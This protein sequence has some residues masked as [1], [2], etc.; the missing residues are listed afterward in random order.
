ARERIRGCYEAQIVSLS[1]VLRETRAEPS[2]ASARERLE[3][4]SRLVRSL[5]EYRDSTRAKLASPEV[6]LDVVSVWNATEPRLTG[7]V[8]TVGPG[9]SFP[10]LR[11]AIDASRPG[12]LLKLGEEKHTWVPGPRDVLALTDVAIVGR[13]AG[14]TR[15][16]VR[17]DARFGRVRLEG[18]TLEGG[19]GDA[20]LTLEEGDAVALEGCEVSYT[21]GYAIRVRPREDRSRRPRSVIYVNGCRFAGKQLARS[22]SEGF[23]CESG[24]VFLRRSSFDEIHSLGLVTPC[25]LDRCSFTNPTDYGRIGWGGFQ[26]GQF[27]QLESG[28]LRENECHGEGTRGFGYGAQLLSPFTYA[29]DDPELVALALGERERLDRRSRHLVSALELERNVPYWIGLLRSEDASVREK[30]AARVLALTGEPVGEAALVGS[31]SGTTLAHEVERSRLLAWFE[32]NEPALAWDA[33]SG[34]YRPRNGGD[35]LPVAEGPLALRA[36]GD[37]LDASIW[38]AVRKTYGEQ[39][40]SV[41]E[42]AGDGLSLAPFAPL[43]RRL[44]ARDAVDACLEASR[45]RANDA[46]LETDALAL[47][48]AGLRGETAPRLSG[49]VVRVGPERTMTDLEQALPSLRPG[50]LVALG[51]GTFSLVPDP[52]HPDGVVPLGEIAFVGQGPDVTTLRLACTGMRGRSFRL[53]LQAL[54][55]EQAVVT[56]RRGA[57]HDASI[58]SSGLVGIHLKNCRLVRTLESSLLR[59]SHVL[60]LAEDCTL[61]ERGSLRP[62]L[63]LRDSCVL[64]RRCTFGAESLGQY[65]IPFVADRCRVAATKTKDSLRLF[66]SRHAYGPTDVSEGAVLVRPLPRGSSFGEPPQVTTFAVASDDMPF[67]EHALG[68]RSLEDARALEL[69][70]SMQP[71]RNLSYWIGLLRSDDANVRKLAAS[72]LHALTGMR[73]AWDGF[74]AP[75]LPSIAAAIERLGAESLDDRETAQREL[76]SAG[77]AAASALEGIATNG[78]PEQR[79]RA[80][81]VLASLEID[82]IEGAEL[83]EIEWARWS[84]WRE[85]RSQDLAWDP[86]TERYVER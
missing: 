56:D 19:R 66:P 65:S 71:S 58:D 33:A 6:A 52:S 57:R 1:R 79:A 12:D 34:R 29:T 63:N 60:V 11:K 68:K 21:S 69:A 84:R 25:V 37:G 74:S 53:R 18:L 13:G 35:A 4:R 83:R 75:T 78:K 80:R 14:R 77:E 48:A 24:L 50:D 82:R 61:D 10:N 32:Q 9:G 40:A 36:S 59:G 26:L 64:A 86:A 8:L 41:L 81:A 70:R 5:V 30:A 16:E 45:L 62:F 49:R 15:L 51:A 20:V 39:V 2:G 76:L 43:A 27:R 28:Y 42:A 72:R 54:T 55:L 67:V 85:D 38:S 46:L 3:R 7:R 73:V 22:G 47:D 17:G 23:A 31:A 44:A